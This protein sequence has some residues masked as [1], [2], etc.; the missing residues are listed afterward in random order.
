VV[1]FS[2]SALSLPIVVRLMS[3]CMY[4]ARTPGVA[5]ADYVSTPGVMSNIDPMENG[6]QVHIPY[7]I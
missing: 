4:A 2:A 6:S 1:D 5:E 3:Q 7:R